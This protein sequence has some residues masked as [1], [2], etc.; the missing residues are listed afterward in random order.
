MGNLGTMVT[1]ENEEGFCKNFD[2]SREISSR[3]IGTIGTMRTIGTMGTLWTVGAIGTVGTMG[4]G[5]NFIPRV[6]Y[7]L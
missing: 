6:S 1:M 7:Q 4:T 3:T 2:V 5:K